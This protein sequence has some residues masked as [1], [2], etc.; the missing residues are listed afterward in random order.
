M[1]SFNPTLDTTQLL[2]ADLEKNCSDPDFVSIPPWIRLSYLHRLQT[3]LL[4][5]PKVSIPPWI[6][7][8]Y[9]PNIGRGQTWRLKVSIPPWIRLSYLLVLTLLRPR[10]LG[11]SIPPWIRLSYLRIGSSVC[12]SWCK[13]QS[14]LGYDSATY[15]SLLR[16]ARWSGCVSI[17]PW[18]RLSYLRHTNRTTMETTAQFQSHLG[19][20]SATYR[21]S[22]WSHRLL[23]GVSIPPWIRL[24]YLPTKRTV[25]LGHMFVCF[26][27][28]LDT[29]QL[30]TEYYKPEALALN[31]FNPTLDTTQLLTLTNHRQRM[32]A[33]EFQSHLGYDSATYLMPGNLLEA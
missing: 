18:I 29:T 7:L 30:L 22:C 10:D 15:C 11:V 24:S 1:P 31:S 9:L 12:T 16:S 32:L 26:N 2:T 28:T 3:P 33:N 19:Y 4:P 5:R 14:H 13:F 25:L 6:R 8:S 17:P 27:P 21:G 23:L 20:D